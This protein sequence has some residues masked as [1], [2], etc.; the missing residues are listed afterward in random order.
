MSKRSR[1]DSYLFFLFFS[2]RKAGLSFPE[3]WHRLAEI[4]NE[5]ALITSMVNRLT[6]RNRYR[7]SSL[8]GKL[9]RWEGLLN[10]RDGVR[11]RLVLL[12]TSIRN[13]F[14]IGA[15]NMQMKLIVLTFFLFVVPFSALVSW[16]Y[17]LGAR[18]DLL[19][20]F[21]LMYPPFLSMISEWATKTDE[22][23]VC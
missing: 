4:E 11:S 5:P 12:E 18:T 14:R 2:L 3:V 15:A 8:S 6:Q 23:L 16:S 17:L 13:R 7:G 20:L 9:H 22:E 10:M 19:V 1:P 21:V